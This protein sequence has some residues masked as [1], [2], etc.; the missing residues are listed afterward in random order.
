M[1]AL[2]LCGIFSG[3]HNAQCFVFLIVDY[4]LILKT[5]RSQRWSRRRTIRQGLA[6]AYYRAEYNEISIDHVNIEFDLRADL[7]DMGRNMRDTS[8]WPTCSFAATT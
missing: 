4:L 2:G 5:C 8:T 3:A 1:S 6:Q 7:I